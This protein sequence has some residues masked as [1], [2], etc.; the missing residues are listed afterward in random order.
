MS[1]R[2]AP[3]TPPYPPQVQEVLD[4]FPATWQPPFRLFTV[5]ARDVRL[6]ER[7]TR[8]SLLDRGHLSL[9]QRELVIDRVTARCGNEYEWG[10][11]VNLYAEKA[12]LDEAQVH[13][14][15]HG[16]ADAPCWGATDRLLIRLCDELHDSCN[17][18]DGLWS[19]L[20][21]VFSEEALLE[22]LMLAGYYRMV[23]YLSN[24]LRLPLEAVG[25]KFPAV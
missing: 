18:S 17:V 8:G 15:V 20:R 10:M 19:E 22:L 16:D 11:H 7:L 23:S 4:R 9:R 14:T 13:A 6:F 1:D 12:G 5:M 24:G 3:A 25:R 2:I 21:A